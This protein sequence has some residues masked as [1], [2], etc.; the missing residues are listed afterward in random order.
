MKK[1]L[2]LTLAVFCLFLN[3]VFAQCTSQIYIVRPSIQSGFLINAVGGQNADSAAQVWAQHRSVFPDYREQWYVETQMPLP[4]ACTGF[5]YGHQKD[6][7]FMTE[8]QI[9]QFQGF[10]LESDTL[11]YHTAIKSWSKTSRRK[12][13][14]S[15]LPDYTL[16]EMGVT[17]PT[18]V[19]YSD[20][21][22]AENIVDLNNLRFG[23]SNEEETVD[24]AKDMLDGLLFGNLRN[25]F[26]VKNPD[27]LMLNISVFDLNGRM[28]NIIEKTQATEYLYSSTELS[29]GLYLVRIAYD[30]SVRTERLF[31]Q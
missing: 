21:K 5:G 28:L 11:L 22:N 16:K 14:I 3:Y 31:I 13:P 1:N 23:S 15:S 30:H 2:T 17:N 26:A 20:S 12:I 6:T 18:V 4:N 24:L 19:V 8:Y 10:L 7:A 25:G 9:F 29:S 27:Q